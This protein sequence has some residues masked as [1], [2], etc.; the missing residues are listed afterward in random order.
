MLIHLK[1]R[2]KFSSNCTSYDGKMPFPLNSTGPWPPLQIG[3]SL[4]KGSVVASDL[5]TIFD[6]ISTQSHK[7]TLGILSYTQYMS[8]FPVNLMVRF[9]SQYEL[10]T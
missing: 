5:F 2:S 6:Q 4:D 7:Q 1:W 9:H 10:I 8:S 3:K